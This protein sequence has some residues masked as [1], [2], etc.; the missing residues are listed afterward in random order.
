MVPTFY[1]DRNVFFAD[2]ADHKVKRGWV[3]KLVERERLERYRPLVEAEVDRLI[4]AFAPDGRCDFLAQFSD[5]MPLHVVRRIMGLPD[6]A[7]PLINRLSVALSEN[8]N[9]PA[10]TPEQVAE[11]QTAWMAL[12]ELNV[13]LLRARAQAPVEGDYVSDLIAEQVA[14]DGALDVNALANHL[15]MT[16]FASAS[17]T[18]RWAASTSRPDH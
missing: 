10:Q 11:L 12:L 6:A 3:L 2:G 1:E 4:H 16:I 18:P 9:N 8:D 15:A 17:P 13:E 5:P 14:R 7:D